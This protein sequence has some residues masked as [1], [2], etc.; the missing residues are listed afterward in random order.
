M[1]STSGKQART[2][3]R[4]DHDPAFARRMGIPSNVAADFHA[5][6]KAAGPKSKLKYVRAGGKRRHTPQAR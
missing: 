3:A 4:A 2:M 5:A 6:D 1:P